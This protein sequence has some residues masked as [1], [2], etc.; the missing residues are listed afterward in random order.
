MTTKN[1]KAKLRQKIT[2]KIEIN[3]SN[4]QG[5]QRKAMIVNLQPATLAQET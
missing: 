1:N 4:F 2:S 5:N 3:K